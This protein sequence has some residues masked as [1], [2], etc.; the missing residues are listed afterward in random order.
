MQLQKLFTKQKMM[1]NVLYSLIP[2]YVFSVY[3]FGWR[4]IALL[5]AVT[6]AGCLGEYWIM[7]MINKD[8]A[9]IS[10]AVLVSCALFTLTL[11][12]TIPIWIAV[13][14]IL[15]GVIIGKCV[16]GGF[17][18]NIFNPALAGRCFIYVSF[19]I[20]M[21][22]KWA[23]PFKGI[24]GGLIKW[25]A[26]PDL[27]TSVTPMI[28]R[29]MNGI[30]TNPVTLFLGNTAGSIGETS[31]LLIIIG[32]IYLIYTKTANWKIMVSVLGS[33][34][35]L[36]S[37]LYFTG[38][39]EYDPLFSLL[40]GGLLFAAVFMATDPVSAP[41]R[42]ISKVIFGCLIGILCVIFR[43]YS[44]FTEGAMFAV[45]I[46]NSFAPLIDRNVRIWEAKKKEKALAQGGAKA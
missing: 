40:A 42:N 8:K 39:S 9:K 18:Q 26:G 36:S 35:V 19:P 29:E 2:I 41:S 14:G 25:A 21:T 45:L 10:E 31:A 17:A 6:V 12:P 13:V 15:F 1:R 5:A 46:A 4:V 37:I 3:L 27:V 16:F 33:A 24:P 11:P 20:P 23:N 34:A 22:V 44:L 7:R 30:A 38:Q 43:T 28:N 32:A